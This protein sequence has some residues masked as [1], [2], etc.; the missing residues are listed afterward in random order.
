TEPSMTPRIRIGNQ[1]A[2]SSADPLGPFEFALAHGF[3]AF[4]WFED[5]KQYPDGTLA[6]WDAD[7]LDAGL[8]ARLRDAGRSR[9]VFFTAPA[10]WPAN[11]LQPDGVPLL[12]RSLDLAADLGADLVNLHLYMDDGAAGY[13]RG[14]EPV[15]R[16]AAALGLR[17]SIENTPHTTPA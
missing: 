5:K 14:L 1:T 2:V 4:E 7:D 13:V 15:L 8:R 6:G 11:P 16:R 10:P 3:D 9:D 12:L 17:V